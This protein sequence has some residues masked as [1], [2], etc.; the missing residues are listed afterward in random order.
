M[1]SKYLDSSHHSV[2]PDYHSRTYSRNNTCWFNNMKVAPFMA[3]P[4]KQYFACSYLQPHVQTKVQNCS[5]PT[6]EPILIHPHRVANLLI[7]Y[8]WPLSIPTYACWDEHWRNVT[9][10]MVHLH[11]SYLVRCILPLPRGWMREM[12]WQRLYRGNTIPTPLSYRH[13]QWIA[14]YINCT[15]IIACAIIWMPST[16]I[17]NK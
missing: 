7:L 13:A 3:W 12:G 2:G 15:L 16:A 10:G 6:P 17:S 4:S 14:T 1:Y 11:R 9:I 5:Q 8:G